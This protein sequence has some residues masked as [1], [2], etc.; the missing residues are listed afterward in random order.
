MQ[1]AELKERVKGLQT[2]CSEHQH[3]VAV[4]ESQLREEVARSAPLHGLN[5]ERLSASQLDGLA[6][7]HERGLKHAKALQV[8]PSLPGAF[9]L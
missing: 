9:Q 3:Q 8:P 6:R 1:V 5:L 4:L 2:A 7:L